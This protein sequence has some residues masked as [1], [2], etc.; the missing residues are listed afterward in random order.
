MYPD[1][2]STRDLINQLAARLNSPTLEKFVASLELLMNPELKFK[3][4]IA[5]AR[6]LPVWHTS[7]L[8]ALILGYDA[9]Q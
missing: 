9:V 2:A 4:W 5:H 7:Y 1:H 3:D 6:V 8:H